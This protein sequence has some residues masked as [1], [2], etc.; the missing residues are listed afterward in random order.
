MEAVN[1]SALE[2]DTKV[3]TLSIQSRINLSLIL[4]FFLVLAGSLSAIYRSE[5]QLTRDVAELTTLATADSYFDSI[6][7]LMLSGA[8]SNRGALQQKILSSTAITEARIIR[9]EGVTS[10]YGPGS[11]DAVIVD[12]LDQRALNGEHVVLEQDDKDGHRLTVVTPMKALADYKGTNCLA[13]HSVEPGS[14]LGAVRVTY[15]FAEMDAQIHRNLFNIALVELGMF[16][17]G[18]LLVAYLL[19]NIVSQPLARVSRTLET[20]AETNNLEIRLPVERDDEVG[21]LSRSVNKMLDGFQQSLNKVHTT[22][23]QLSSASLQIREIADRAVHSSDSQIKMS[24]NVSMAISQMHE[25]GMSVEGVANQTLAASQIA[26][27]ES[28]LGSEITDRAQNIMLE[29]RESIAG[30][31]DVI[32]AL[33]RQ[34][35]NV[36]S[37][38]SVI[39][40]IAEQ[41][42]LLALNAAIEAARAG[43]QGRGFSVVADEV[44]KLAK[45]THEATEEIQTIIVDLQNGARNA[46]GAMDQAQ[47]S[48]EVSVEQVQKTAA[49]LG[50]I[51]H[52]VQDINNT[53]LQVVDAVQAQR[54]VG[55]GVES[56]VDEISS[57]AANTTTQAHELARVSQQLLNLS[58]ELKQLIN[59][60]KI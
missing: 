42:N 25:A 46:V 40:Q 53:N 27:R 9:G 31:S 47:S 5:T 50:T 14:V 12:E 43:E 30:A 32:Q 52:E 54:Q 34:S 49:A 59:Q 44:R 56:H 20:L 16:I 8:M 33:D 15:D 23:E 35:Q 18:I 41:T 29:L 11:A 36:G 60:F 39:Q 38:L 55:A 10:M 17:A 48:A 1:K 7:I 22:L 3:S 2:E 6:N 21:K 28:K 19:R 37:V 57:S 51:S 24:R 4:V 58:T 13:C 45:R 26:L